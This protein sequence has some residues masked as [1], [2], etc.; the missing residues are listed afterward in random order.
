MEIK[1]TITV[2]VPASRYCEKCI[3][4]AK[5]KNGKMFCTL[6]NVYICMLRGKWLKCYRCYKALYDAISRED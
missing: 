3:R 4:K 2:D 1:T 6:Y 5:D